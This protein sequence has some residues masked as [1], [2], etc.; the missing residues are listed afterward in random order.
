MDRSNEWN[1][2]NV[3]LF[4]S[5]LFNA[6]HEFIKRLRD[7][8]C[9]NE[10]NACE[11]HETKAIHERKKVVGSEAVRSMYIELCISHLLIV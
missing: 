11:I 2:R 4:N 3:S 8:E 9:A 1:A 7:R 5:Q 10:G 6:L